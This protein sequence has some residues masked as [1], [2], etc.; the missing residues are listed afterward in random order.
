MGPNQHRWDPPAVSK[1]T[2]G[3]NVAPLLSRHSSLGAGLCSGA[4]R[5]LLL[6]AAPW[7]AGWMQR[8][9]AGGHPLGQGWQGTG[10]KGS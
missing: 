1:A 5:A 4:S 10:R 9:A 3:T 8:G 6:P 2:P 7:C